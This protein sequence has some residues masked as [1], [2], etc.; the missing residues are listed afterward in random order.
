MKQIESEHQKALFDWIRNVGVRKYPML[1]MVFAIPN[2]G[3]RNKTTA[4]NLKREGV[5]SGGWDIF[6]PYPNQGKAG[7]FLEMKAGKNKLTANQIKFRDA[8]DDKYEFGVAY[9]WSEAK[10]II[11]KYINYRRVENGE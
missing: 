10:N 5:L 8:L 6:L 3:K 2:G 11:L 4:I 9:S 1:E 7:L